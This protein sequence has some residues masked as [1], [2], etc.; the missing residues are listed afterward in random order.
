MLDSRIEDLEEGQQVI[1]SVNLLVVKVLEKSDQTNILRYIYTLISKPWES[2]SFVCTY[3]GVA[4]L[5]VLA[6]HAQS[7]GFAPQQLLKPSIVAVCSPIILALRTIPL[8]WGQEG[9]SQFN[10]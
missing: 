8:K 3:K 2:L 7:P 1:R 6:Q 5:V 4:Q 10:F 9:Q